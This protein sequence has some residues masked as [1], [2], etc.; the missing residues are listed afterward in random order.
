VTLE[1]GKLQS[2]AAQFGLIGFDIEYS[3]NRAHKYFP[4]YSTI[5][6]LRN[7]RIFSIGCKNKQSIPGD[8]RRPELFASRQMEISFTP[9][10]KFELKPY[11]GNTDKMSRFLW[12]IHSL[13]SNINRP[14]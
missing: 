5:L 9:V 10:Q 7:K 8:I 4:F 12:H 1:S 11:S 2:L 3:Q 13:Y 6:I 14:I